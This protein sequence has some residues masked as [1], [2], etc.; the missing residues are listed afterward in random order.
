MRRQEQMPVK[1]MCYIITQ[2]TCAQDMCYEY[3]TFS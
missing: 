1:D 3:Y 2:D